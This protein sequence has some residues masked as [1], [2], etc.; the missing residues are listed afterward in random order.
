MFEKV[1][2]WGILGTA[3]IA[4]KN[5]L[6]IA[7]ASNATLTAVAS[8]THV[9]AQRFINECS[10]QVPF[11]TKPAPVAAYAALLE[12]DDVDAVYIPLP[13]ALRREWVIRA[14]E[15]GKHV[16]GE[17]PAATSA[18]E[19]QE[20]LDACRQHHVQYMDGV[21]F[22]HSQR[23][24]MIRSLLDDDLQLGKL[25]RLVSQF[26]FASD[27]QFQTSNI[28]VMS[29][30]EPYGCLGDLGW[31]CIR[32]FLWSLKGC[33]PLEVRARS[34]SQL[35]GRGS[36]AAVPGEFSAELI[37]PDGVSASFYCSFLTEQQQWVHA[38][39]TRG[40]MKVDDFVLPFHGCEASACIGHDQFFID[41]CT[42]NMEHHLTRHSVREYASGIS[43]AQEVR[44]I[45]AF[46]ALAVS[47]KLDEQWPT[48]TLKTQQVLDACFASSRNDG[49]A[50]VVRS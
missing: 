43:G 9:A 15:A 33:L 27:G 1:C 48:W 10:G 2:R 23:L 25:R 4:R 19:V 30:M 28:R 24:P 38:S 8:R 39:G 34:L 35:R 7:A 45:E 32:F 46:S 22:M 21:M 17:K 20:M 16:L 41:N 40:Y 13:T 49:Q 31:Y 6:A 14:A 42:F 26:S 50:I 37:F 44:M 47:G 12:R 11:E 3:G 5:W 29:N 18:S 36:P